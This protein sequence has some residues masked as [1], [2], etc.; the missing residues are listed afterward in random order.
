[1]PRYIVKWEYIAGARH[2]PAGKAVELSEA[3][4]AYIN[5]DSRGVLELIPEYTP[6]EPPFQPE[7]IEPASELPPELEE[8]EGPLQGE[9]A[10][11]APQHDRMVKKP[12]N[13]RGR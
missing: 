4:A 9:R 12:R 3:E 10:L 11:D 5:R 2:L 13:K 7:V 1:M 8:P 6:P